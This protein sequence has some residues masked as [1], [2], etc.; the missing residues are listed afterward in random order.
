[1]KKIIYLIS[2]NK[3]HKNFYQNLEEVFQTKKVKFFQIRLKDTPRNKIIEISKKIKILTK[4]YK[5]K[6]IINDSINLTNKINADGCHL[7]QKDD[8]LATAKNKLKNKVFGV[9][10]HNSKNLCK[11]AVRYNANYVALGSYFK[12]KLKPK[13]KLSNINTLKWAKKKLNVPIVAIGGITNKNYKKLLNHGA[14]YIALSSY[15]WNNRIL[16]PHEAIR[17]F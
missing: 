7:G 1:M 12:S 9:T 11:R 8:D 5:V 13:A 17:K 16:K 4:K 10:C 14:N 15:I 2:P 6:L 3:I